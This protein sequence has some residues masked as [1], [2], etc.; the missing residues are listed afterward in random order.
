MNNNKFILYARKS[1]ESEERQVQSIEDQIKFC[2]IKAKQLWIEIIA[3]F[4]D[5]KS[6]KAPYVRTWFNEMM[7]MIQEGKIWGIIAW[8]LDRLTRNP[9]DTGSIQY[10]LQKWVI[11]RIITNDREYFPWDSGLLFSVETWM[12]NQFILDLSK[13]T[14]RGMRWKAERWWLWCA[15]PH[16]YLND[17]LNKTVIIDP[18]RFLLV[19]KMWDLLLKEKYSVSKI[20]DI[21]NND[22]WYRTLQ[23]KNSWGKPI[24]VG[25]LHY[26]FSSPFYAWKLR[27][28]GTLMAGN[29]VPMITLDEFAEAQRILWRNQT[30][31]RPQTKEF[32][33]TGIIQC[34]ECGCKITAECKSKTTVIEKKVLHF[35]YYHCTHKKDTREKKCSQRK[36]INEKVL[37]SQIANILSSLEIRPEF[38]TWAKWVLHRL[39]GDEIQKQES[40]FETLNKR[41]EE[42]KKKL[43]KLLPLLM[44]ELITENEYKVNKSQIEEELKLL[45]SKRNNSNK[46]TRNW[47]EVMEN[48]L[49][50]IWTART[51]FLT[52]NIATKKSIFRAIGSNLV[53]MDGKLSVAVNSWFQPFTKVVSE[54]SSPLSRLE[55]VKKSTSMRDTDALDVEYLKWLGY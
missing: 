17:K 40:V 45:E 24:C 54:Q 49:D 50:F 55:P 33:Y 5:E 36:H 31:E 19:R 43:W 20:A 8:K 28:K 3:T 10:S 14:Q 48:A 13:N 53:M 4:T 38:V 30:G 25:S 35:T 32:A 9:I 47:I 15:A 12:A 41:I 34:W 23:K 16:W 18:D 2:K 46:E 21:A 11:E 7:A 1:N 27:F 42:E 6:A 51:M 26:I 52:W 29:H 22:W 37:E 39:H 44:S